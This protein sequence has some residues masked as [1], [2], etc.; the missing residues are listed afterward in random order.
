VTSSD[1]LVLVDKPSGPTSHDVIDRVRRVLGLRRVGHAG[2][3]DPFASGLL[4]VLLGR[5]TRLAQFLVGLSKRYEG[6][7]RLGVATETDDRTGAV[8]VTQDGAERIPD[9]AL[10]E[11]MA[12]LVGAQLQRPPA[13]SAKK[14][15]GRRAYRLARSGRTVALPAVDVEIFQFTPIAREGA[16]V[17]FEALVS[18]GTYVRALARDLGERLGCGAHLAELRRTAVGAFEIGA[19]EPLATLGKPGTTVLPPLAAVPHLERRALTDDERDA[20]AHGRP[21]SADAAA[22]TPLALVHSDQLVAVAERSGDTL[23]PRVV[24]VD[25]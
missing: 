21:I 24:L 3:L 2:T 5:A 19:A 16:T 20:A 22:S 18:S 15:G 17:R 14:V 23:R 1:G 4:L 8:T 25:G 12:S 6:S 11:A 9:S 10:Q 13:Y 7:I